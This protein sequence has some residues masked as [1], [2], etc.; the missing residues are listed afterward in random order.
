MEEIGHTIYSGLW[1]LICEIG[2]IYCGARKKGKERK[3]K[4]K[5]GEALALDMFNT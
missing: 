4:G 3:R 5:R 1:G 2:T